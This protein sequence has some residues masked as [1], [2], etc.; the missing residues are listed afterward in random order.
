MIAAPALK[1]RVH[2]GLPFGGV[3]EFVGTLLREPGAQPKL[4]KFLNHFKLRLVRL[5]ELDF[6][7][8]ITMRRFLLDTPVAMLTSGC[9]DVHRW[10]NHSFV[11]PEPVF[12]R[13]PIDPEEEAFEIE[14]EDVH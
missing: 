10:W 14:L 7:D 1:W 12:A 9:P 13:P 3:L 2:E 5:E 4:S 11:D 6:V 8:D